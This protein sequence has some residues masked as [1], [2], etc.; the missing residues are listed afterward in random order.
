MVTNSFSFY[1]SGKVSLLHFRWTVLVNTVLLLD[2]F[3]STLNTSLLACKICVEK[4]TYTLMGVPLN[5]MSYFSLAAFKIL[6]LSLTSDNLIIK[7]P[8]GFLN[9]D[10][11]SSPRFGKFSVII[12]LNKLSV[13][14]CFPSGITMPILICSMMSHKSL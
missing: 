11:I 4:S 12:S 7:C 9:L 1:L 6:S 14:F 5:V 10:A 2:S 3:F 8:L 13:P